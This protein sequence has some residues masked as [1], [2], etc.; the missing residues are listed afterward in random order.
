MA[1]RTELIS[2]NTLTVSDAQFLTGDT[3]GKA[4]CSLPP[5]R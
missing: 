4:S 5:T 2:I 3:N 1:A